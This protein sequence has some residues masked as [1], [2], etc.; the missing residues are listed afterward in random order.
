MPANDVEI[1]AVYQVTQYTVT[2][3]STNGTQTG[4]G[5]YT[6][7]D[8]VTLTA[9]PNPGYTFVSWNVLTSASAPLLGLQT[10]DSFGMPSSNVEV[11]AVYEIA[12]NS[13]GAG[14]ENDPLITTSYGGNPLNAAYPPD[15]TRMTTFQLDGQQ[16]TILEWDF[17][18]NVDKSVLRLYDYVYGDVSNHNLVSFKLY[19]ATEVLGHG[20]KSWVE[21]PF[22]RTRYVNGENSSKE[23]TNQYLATQIVRDNPSSPSSPIYSKMDASLDFVGTFDFVRARHW[24]LDMVQYGTNEEF[25]IDGA[26]LEHSTNTLAPVQV[27]SSGEAWIN[28]SSIVIDTFFTNAG[29]TEPLLTAA[30]LKKIMRIYQEPIIA[31]QKTTL[32]V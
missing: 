23:T 15:G 21:I 16:Q 27:D 12:I 9:T 28:G 24:K 20:S 1:T 11:E 22:T 2:V 17:G 31:L 18:K 3:S 26:I 10:G 5:S 14:T 4:D 32:T 6:P 7:G 13:T 29:H 30:I 19:Y 25:M 8:T